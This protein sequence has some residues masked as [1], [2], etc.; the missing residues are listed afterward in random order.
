MK[1][2]EAIK[3]D[4]RSFIIRGKRE[5]FRGGEFHYFRTPH[6]LWEDR[7]IKM[8]RSGSNLVTTYIPWNWHEQ[9]EGKQRWTGDRDLVQFIKLCTKH[10]MYI[11]VKPGP[12][13]CAELDFGGHPDWLLRKKIPLRVLSTQYLRYVEKWYKKIAEIINPYLVTNGGNIFCIQV[14]NEY[15]HLIYYGE[16]KI[17]YKDAIAY[18][19][20]LK[21][22]MEKYG[23][24]IPKFA[25]EAEFLRGK[26]LIDTRTYYPNIPLFGNWKWQFEHYDEKIMKAKAG[27]P[28]FPTMILELEVGWFGMFG[29]PLFLPELNL[30]EGIS[31]TVLIEG[32]SVLN[33]Y[34]FVGG[35]TLPFWGSRGNIYCYME[36]KG[37]GLT[38]SF[39]FGGA[40]IREWG[41]LMPERYYWIKGFN[42]FI[43]DYISLILE[44]DNVDDIVVLS[45][46]EDVQLIR[47]GKSG[48]DTAL[49]SGTEKFKIITKRRGDEYLTCVRNLSEESR[50]VDIGWAANGEP[51]FK[52]LEVQSHE[53]FLLP[54]GVKV[55]GTNL[56]IVSST[57]ELLF[58]EKIDKQVLFGLYGK[59]DRRGETVLNIS[60]SEV[61]VLSGQVLVEARGSQAVLK[62]THRGIHIL[63]IQNDIFFILDQTLVGSVEKLKNGILIADTYFVKDIQRQGNILLL[64]TEMRNNSNNQFSY[65]GDE[66]IVSVQ[67]DG[68]PVDVTN[69]PALKKTSFTFQNPPDQPVQVE[70]RGDW[71]VKA[72]TT[73]VNPKYND[74]SWTVIKRP[75][76]LE[77]AGL[78]EHGYIWYRAEFELPAGSKEVTLFYPGN[79]TDRQYIYING[80]L[81]WSGITELEEVNIQDAIKPGKNF[82]VVLYQNFFHNKSHPHEG[83]IKKYSG[84]M[85]SVV[86]KGKN[87]GKTFTRKISTFKV[88]QHLNGILQGYAERNYD[89]SGWQKVKAGQGHKYVVTEEIGTILWMRRKFKFRTKKNWKFAVRLTIPKAEQR[90]FICIN[91]KIIGWFEA[92]GPQHEFYVPEPFLQEENVLSI[93]LEGPK[94]SYIV[95]PE[96]GTFYETRG[97]DIQ[98]RFKE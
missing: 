35:T 90:C 54:V 14:E 19:L 2:K 16:E 4:A 89:D 22:M 93:I 73:E 30:T 31:K 59:S 24:D 28:N 18:F 62:Y 57:S 52:G 40:P 63:K 33:Y 60:P 77:E 69:D 68:R 81:V 21:R 43:S 47:T 13:C 23:I 9:F 56:T 3:C 11:I 98:I 94:N 8:K 10:D 97:L 70:W 6:E 79:N 44:S 72:D 37:M 82:M 26:G 49:A 32:A 86:I 15:D 96:I 83:A 87:R 25:N 95:E 51:I 61:Q 1:N 17:T 67:V 66:P 5:L 53:T 75:V 91:G 88:R 12:Y 76:S 34:M 39:D 71:K 84:I 55:P 7:I 48:P 42:L 36:P 64:K 27:Q 29:Q 80:Q 85:K 65:F 46:G 41:E 50:T 78:L 58:V 45:G 38:T 20:R 74:S 92:I